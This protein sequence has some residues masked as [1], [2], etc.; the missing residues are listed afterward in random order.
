[1]VDGSTCM[2]QK[3][4]R[5]HITQLYERFFS[6]HA[7]QGPKLNGVY[8]GFIE[9]ES[10]IRLERSFEETEV[11]EVVKAVNSDKAPGLDGFPTAF[12]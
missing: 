11:L 1:M 2:D 7:D 6:E 3:E 8:F 10:F 5:S 9:E 4:I 12:L